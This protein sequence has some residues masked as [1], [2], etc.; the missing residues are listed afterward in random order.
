MRIS[1]EIHA[2][3]TLAAPLKLGFFFLVSPASFGLTR[4]GIRILC[5]SSMNVTTPFASCFISQQS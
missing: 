3:G 2:S 1:H 5:R 4:C